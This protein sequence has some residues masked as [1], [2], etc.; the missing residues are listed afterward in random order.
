MLASGKVTAFGR[1]SA[2]EL[3]TKN[4]TSKDGFDWTKQFLET[5]GLRFV[6]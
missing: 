3:I 1:D 4:V 2:M 5:E 6:V